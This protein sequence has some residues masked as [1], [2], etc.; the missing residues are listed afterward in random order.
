MS[1]TSCTNP[2]QIRQKKLLRECEHYITNIRQPSRLVTIFLKKNTKSYHFDLLLINRN[3]SDIE[4]C[5]AYA[6]VLGTL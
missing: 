3:H 1:S 5:I 2:P 6:I 4:T